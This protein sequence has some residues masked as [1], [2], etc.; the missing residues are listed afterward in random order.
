MQHV[1]ND[2]N[3]V[4]NNADDTA[5]RPLD[6]TPLCEGVYRKKIFSAAAVGST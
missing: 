1:Q 4:F 6:P 5:P 2:N 3:R